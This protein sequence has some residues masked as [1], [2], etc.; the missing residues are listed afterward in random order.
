MMQL[1]QPFW[2]FNICHLSIQGGGLFAIQE[3]K[4]EMASAET[5]KGNKLEFSFFHTFEINL[6]QYFQLY[7]QRMV[8]T[9]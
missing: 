6:Q 5:E 3:D 9:S 2:E 7:I 8:F 4:L 1:N